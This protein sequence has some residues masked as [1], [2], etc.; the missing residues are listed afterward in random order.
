[1][2]T[3]TFLILCLVFLMNPTVSWAEDALGAIAGTIGKLQV[4]VPIWAEQSDFYG[5]GNTGG[6]SLM[7]TPVAR[8]HGLGRLSL[9]FEGSDFLGGKL[10][11]FELAIGD[12]TAKNSSEYF[13]NLDDGLQVVITRAEKRDKT[14]SVAGTVRGKLIWRQLMPVSKRKEDPSR[15]LLV[16]L[17]FDVVVANEY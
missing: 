5:D 6:V 3:R 11:S 15:Q 10:V 13:G 8:D 16:D 2:M 4:N 17:A 9:G 14:L 7:T 1:M 12:A